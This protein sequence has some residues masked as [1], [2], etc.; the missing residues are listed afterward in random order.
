MN[1]PEGFPPISSQLIE[2]L[3]EA[4]PLRD[5]F[6][7]NTP[8]ETLMYYYGQRAVIRFLQ[9]QYKIQNENILTK[10]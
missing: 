10:D 2:R 8:H 5:D 1:N 3:D 6:E 7:P 4:F 9:S